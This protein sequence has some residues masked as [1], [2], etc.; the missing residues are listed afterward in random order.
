MLAQGDV[1]ALYD[2]SLNIVAEYTYDSWGKLLSVTGSL[3][4]TVGKANPF[5]YRGYYYDSETELYYL[6]SR[7]YDPETGRFINAD[8]YVS[9]GQGVLGNNMFAYCGNNPVVRVDFGGEHWY[10]LLLDDLWECITAKKNDTK[11]TSHDISLLAPEKKKPESSTYSKKDVN[12]Y[13]SGKGGKIGSKVNVELMPNHKSGNKPNPNIKIYDSYK[14]RRLLP[15]LCKPVKWYRIEISFWR[16]KICQGTKTAR[17]YG[18]RKKREKKNYEN[19]YH[20]L[21]WRT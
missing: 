3:A 11:E 14:I 17:R 21:M 19:F 9:T 7:Y 13:V 4:E 5:R 16:L 6:N 18:Q 1:L 2:N 15:I 20:C 8:G 10:F 12:I